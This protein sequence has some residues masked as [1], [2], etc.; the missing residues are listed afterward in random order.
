MAKKRYKL[1]EEGLLVAQEMLKNKNNY[2]YDPE[3]HPALLISLFKG[4][5]TV[6]AFCSA[7]PC[8][9][10]TFYQWVKRHAEFSE[11]YA[12]SKE[13]ASMYWNMKALENLNDPSFNTKLYDLIM[14]NRGFYTKDRV[15]YI[16][17]LDNCK[18]PT[19]QFDCVKQQTA[20][21]ELSP[22][23]LKTLAGAI[24]IGAQIHQLTVLQEDVEKLKKEALEFKNEH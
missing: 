23:E 11:A 4:G 1:V 2:K 3:Y 18:T 10:E 5:H 13:F 21:G 15:V 16:R 6:S 8:T 24:A 20:L 14:K 19:E 9:R 12:L 17:G 22:E 7:V